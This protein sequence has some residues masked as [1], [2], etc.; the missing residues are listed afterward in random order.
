[1]LFDPQGRGVWRNEFDKQLKED[2]AMLRLISWDGEE[3]AAYRTEGAHH[4]FTMLPDG[5]FGLIQVQVRDWTNPENGETL[6]VAGDAIV[7]MSPDGATSTEIWNAFDDLPVGPNEYWN[8]PFYPVPIKDWTHGNSIHYYPDSDTYLLSLNHQLA[9]YEIDRH[10]AILRQFGGEDTGGGWP[11]YTIAD[12]SMV[13]ENQHD[14]T[15]TD[16]GTL[17][18]FANEYGDQNM[19]AGAVEYAI[20]DANHTLTEQWRYLHYPSRI[21][22]NV[23]RLGNGDIFVNFA[24]GGRWIELAP[25]HETK[26]WENDV[27]L[28]ALFGNVH[29]FTDFATG[30]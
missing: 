24:L 2:V 10:G 8:V 26:V 1:V 20:D 13:F 14:V 16:E 4:T 17:M 27:D 19:T 29:P 21:L 11:V 25:D 22:G 9:A 6:Q 28:G 30:E 3:L 12:G 7:E 15:F 23:K 18:M 5:T